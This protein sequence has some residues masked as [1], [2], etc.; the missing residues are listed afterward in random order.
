MAD[1]A[2]CVHEQIDDYEEDGYDS[3]CGIGMD[4]KA[5]HCSGHKEFKA[6]PYV[7]H[8]TECDCKKCEGRT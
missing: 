7:E 1:C 8:N 3:W 6:N 2:T 5:L 4:E